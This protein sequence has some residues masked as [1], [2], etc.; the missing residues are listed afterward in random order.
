MGTSNLRGDYAQ[1]SDE[2]LRALAKNYRDLRPEAQAA[3]TAE[4]RRRGLNDK[5]QDVRAEQA[6]PH[7]TKQIIPTLLSIIPAPGRVLSNSSAA[8][9]P[10]LPADLSGLRQGR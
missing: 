4:L 5:E 7:R 3:L 9:Q 2:K 1:F 6:A 8:W 10:F